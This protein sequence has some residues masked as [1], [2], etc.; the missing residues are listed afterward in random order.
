MLVFRMSEQR[1]HTPMLFCGAIAYTICFRNAGFFLWIDLSACLHEL[2]WDAEDA[3]KQRLYDY[4]VE[5]SS[6]HAY[7]AETPGRFRFLFSV[8]RDTVIEG[9]QR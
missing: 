9:L 4:G 1:K 3:L 5:M 6:G 2:S 8:D 7:H